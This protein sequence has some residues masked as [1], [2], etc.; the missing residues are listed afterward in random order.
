[1]QR[2]L[3]GSITK[4]SLLPRYVDS[5][6][7][8]LIQAADARAHLLYQSILPARSQTFVG[9]LADGKEIKCRMAAEIR[10]ATVGDAAA[11]SAIYSHFVRKT[12]VSFESEPPDVEE[13]ARRIE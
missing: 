9:R 6:Q 4:F 3:R 5:R 7:E 10:L 8:I 12:P 2:E 1:M 13:I 11:V